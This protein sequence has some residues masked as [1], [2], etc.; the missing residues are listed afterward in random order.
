[1]SNPINQHWV[2][3]FYLKHFAIPDSQYSKNPKIWVFSR[4][5][6]ESDPFLV[7]VRKI[8]AK[9][10]LYSPTSEDGQRYFDLESKLQRMENI[11][12]A[13]WPY[14]AENFVDLSDEPIR[15]GISLFMATLLLRHPSNMEIYEAMHGNLVRLIGSFPKDDRGLPDVG[16]LEINGEFSPLDNS[17]WGKY[18]TWEKNDHHHFFVS[19]V[20][21]QAHWLANLLMRKRWSII[22]SDA[23]VF[24][25]S[26][27]PIS[28]Q[29]GKQEKFGFNTPGATILFP[30]SPTRLLSLDDRMQEPANQYYSLGVHGPGPINLLV[31]RN[32]TLMLCNRHPNFV[33]SEIIEWEDKYERENLSR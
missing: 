26:D 25:T 9:R 29:H 28:K 14:I 31:W 23:P 7:S 27:N 1:M 15:K 12:S 17:N 22:F 30:L 33:M 8:C 11:L 20:D 32:A 5:K 3:Q 2:P 18:K 10:Y 19:M 6:G 24:I 16:G 4:E 13:T 21:S